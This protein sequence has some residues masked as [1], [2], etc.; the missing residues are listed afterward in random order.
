MSDFQ[1]TTMKAHLRDS[2]NRV[3]RLERSL[4]G[5]LRP[6]NQ[7]FVLASGITGSFDLNAYGSRLIVLGFNLTAAT[8]P[9]IGATIATLANGA[10]PPFAIGFAGAASLDFQVR[11]DGTIVVTAGPATSMS[12]G[13]MFT[14]AA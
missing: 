6:K 12:G 5:L 11:P 13:A 3:S 14:A 10:R 4:G 9:A 7:G 1:P 2:A 8:A